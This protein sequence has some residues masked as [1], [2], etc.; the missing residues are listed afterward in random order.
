MNKN[1]NGVHQESFKTFSKNMNLTEIILT[2]SKC[3]GIHLT[4]R[5]IIKTK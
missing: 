4:I 1:L 5:R 3:M 2:I